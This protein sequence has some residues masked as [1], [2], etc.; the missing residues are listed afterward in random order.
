[1]ENK[2]PKFSAIKEKAKQAWETITADN[3]EV[4]LT[5]SALGLMLFA[6]GIGV[7]LGIS[8]CITKVELNAALRKQRKML[9]AEMSEE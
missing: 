2:S 6:L 8:R 1:M 9:L 7:S 4:T 5:T 3:I